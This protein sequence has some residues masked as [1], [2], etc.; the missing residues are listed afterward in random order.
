M[1]RNMTPTIWPRS[2]A[3]SAKDEDP[4]S[5]LF[6]DGKNLKW[7]PMCYDGCYLELRIL[8]RN[9]ILFWNEFKYD[10]ILNIKT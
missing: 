7:L 1:N 3:T 10:L 8:P 6:S 9:F 4:S 2:I 5:S